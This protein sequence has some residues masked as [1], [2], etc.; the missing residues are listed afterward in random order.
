MG[1]STLTI[2][3]KEGAV[4]STFVLPNK[5][6]KLVPVV[7]RDR[8]MGNSEHDG[9]FMFTGCSQSFVLPMSSRMKRLIEPLTDEE[10]EYLSDKLKL[11][12]DI[13]SSDCFYH[14]HRIEIKKTSTD[15]KSLSLELD[16]SRPLDYLEYKILLQVPV[17][18]NSWA[19]R[20]SSP[21]YEWAI[22]DLG[23]EFEQKVSL[24]ELKQKAYGWL[25]KNDLSQTKLYDMVR[26]YGTNISAGASITELK[27]VLVD[28]IETPKS[29]RKL[30][31]LLNDKDFEHK[32]FLDKAIRVGEINRVG[33]TKYALVGGE[34]IGNTMRE[35]IDYLKDKRNS[36]VVAAIQDKI[37]INKA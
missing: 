15:L 19:E 9:L 23:E 13:N 6:V 12:L 36:V 24:G 31:D 3:G 30:V 17:V 27:S 37:E 33:T 16:L 21:E 2:K 25:S 7:R 32:L 34:L 4:K 28:I 14:S 22:Q 26:V 5:K 29:L 11:N 20:N 8:F 18:A 35:T 1:D 10:R